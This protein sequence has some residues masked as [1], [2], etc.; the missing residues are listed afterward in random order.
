MGDTPE[1]D[2]SYMFGFGRRKCTQVIVRWSRLC[3]PMT[4]LLRSGNEP[5]AAVF[6]HRVCDVPGDVEHF[7][8][9]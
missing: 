4:F 2:P 5:R 1:P 3:L 9:V 6:I 8:S 7:E